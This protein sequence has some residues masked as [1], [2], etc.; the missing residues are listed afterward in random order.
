MSFKVLVHRISTIRK[1]L[2]L[3]FMVALFSI[4][5]IDLWLINNLK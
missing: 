2:K 4:V 5:I 3:L 1:D